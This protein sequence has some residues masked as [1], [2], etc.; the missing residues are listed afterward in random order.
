[1]LA[2]KL[3]KKLTPFLGVGSHL[4]PIMS[5]HAGE[6]FVRNW[7]P[8]LN[9][10]N[11]HRPNNQVHYITLVRILD[12]TRLTLNTDW[13]HKDDNYQPFADLLQNSY[14]EPDGW[15]ISGKDWYGRWTDPLPSEYR[16]E[17]PRIGMMRC[18]P[19]IILGEKI[20]DSCVL[21]T[22]DYRLLYHGNKKARQDSRKA[23]HRNARSGRCDED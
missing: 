22:K 10:R 20:P 13:I 7:V 18:V 12:S 21:W 23:K 4:V 14:T 9:R 15:C 19:E 1:M 17:N 2:I 5:W 3:H 6:R 8:I 16:M 11:R